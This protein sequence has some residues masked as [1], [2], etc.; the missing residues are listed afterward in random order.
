M[1]RYIDFLLWEEDKLN[2]FIYK[3]YSHQLPGQL[4]VLDNH[5][6]CNSGLIV[7]CSDSCLIG[8]SS[9]VKINFVTVMMEGGLENK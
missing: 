6:W 8:I 3:F 4:C 7:D 9:G 1:R 5:Y 2:S